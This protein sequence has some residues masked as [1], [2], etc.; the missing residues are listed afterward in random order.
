MRKIFFQAILL[1]AVLLFAASLYADDIQ[2][3]DYKSRIV[4]TTGKLKD[5]EK[6]DI[7]KKLAL[8][9]KNGTVHMAILIVNTTKPLEISEYS[10]KVAEKWQVGEKGK[11]NGLIFTIAIKDKKARLEVGRGLEGNIPDITAKHIL[12]EEIAPVIKKAGLYAGINQSIESV[13]THMGIITTDST[14]K[15][16]KQ[17]KDEGF[18]YT[19]ELIIVLLVGIIGGLICA[20]T[21]LFG[22]PLSAVASV[23]L[24]IGLLTAFSFIVMI[25]AIALAIIIGAITRS[26]GLD[27]I[28]LDSFSYGSSSGSSSFDLSESFSGGG[29]GIFDGGG[30]DI[31]IDFDL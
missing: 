3:P 22:I 16:Q 26:G 12:A 6:A 20:N 21:F 1:I 10:I 5:L 23:G 30:A 9:D 25:I 28:P 27:W 15:I 8:L 7:E 29:G 31:S 4:D 13:K 14:Q 2:I 17:N 11:D 24:I 18:K 19:R